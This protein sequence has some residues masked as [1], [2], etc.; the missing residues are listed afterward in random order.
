LD[1]GTWYVT[2]AHKDLDA[3]F[4][5]GLMYTIGL[6]GIVQDDAKAVEC[7]IDAAKRGH[8]GAKALLSKKYDPKV[9]TLK[10]DEYKGKATRNLENGN[11]ILAGYFTEQ[12]NKNYALAENINSLIEQ[13][14]KATGIEH[15]NNPKTNKEEA[16]KEQ[17]FSKSE[18]KEEEDATEVAQQ[19]YDQ[20]KYTL[21]GDDYKDE[22]IKNLEDGNTIL[23]EY[24]MEEANKKYDLAEDFQWKLQSIPYQNTDLA[25]KI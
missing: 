21:Q 20:N 18:V 23:A 24:L 19:A 17:P 15:T 25:T 1:A 9:Y 2:M 10:G 11:T 4:K 14:I 13:S 5:L 16:L 3:Q 12:A 7:F 6:E 22:A 8:V